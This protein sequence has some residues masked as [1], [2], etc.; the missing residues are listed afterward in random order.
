MDKDV[1]KNLLEETDANLELEL[2]V[3]ANLHVDAEDRLGNARSALE[4]A[5]EEW[6]AAQYNLSE[7]VKKLTQ[8]ETVIEIK[9]G[10]VWAKMEGQGK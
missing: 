10:N 5:E 6:Q 1:I 9:S 7:T 8:I 3:R 2:S 4:Y